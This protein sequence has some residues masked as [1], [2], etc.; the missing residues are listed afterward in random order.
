M[1]GNDTAMVKRPNTGANVEMVVVNGYVYYTDTTVGSVDDMALLVEAA[2]SGGVNS[3]WEGRLIF[4]DGS[5]KVVTIEK[6][7]DDKDDGVAIKE[8]HE[9]TATNPNIDLSGG[10][11]ST[12]AAPMLVSYEVSKDVYTLTRIGYKNTDTTDTTIDTNGYDAYVTG[13]TNLKT[14]GSIKKISSSGSGLT[15]GAGNIDRMYYESTG[16]VFVKYDDKDQEARDKISAKEENKRTEAEKALLTATTSDASYKVV[17]GKTA[18]NYDRNL[19]A[20]AAVANK[21]GN[22]YYAQAAYISMGASERPS[23]SG[24]PGPAPDRPAGRCPPGPAAFST[25]SRKGLTGT[26]AYDRRH[27]KKDASSPAVGP[28]PAGPAGRPLEAGRR[29]QNKMSFPGRSP[30]RRG[31]RPG[32]AADLGGSLPFSAGPARLRWNRGSGRRT[33]K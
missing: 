23:G 12:Y 6:K 19:S 20:V 32:R 29:S 3:K 9:G 21:S 4:S 22:S 15:V 1:A 33:E 8:F 24:W 13:S 25:G 14:D 5:D 18:T 27:W 16:V 11:A 7:W 2:P 31:A 28:D 30:C 26:R 17:T 10:G